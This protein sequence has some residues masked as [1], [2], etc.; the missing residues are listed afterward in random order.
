MQKILLV[1][2]FFIPTVMA[3]SFQL[4]KPVICDSTTLIF[5]ALFEQAGERPM[6]L[7]RGDGVDT[8]QTV[9]LVNKSTKTWTIV[10]FNKDKACVLESGVGSREIFNGPVI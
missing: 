8:S 1:I 3:Q 10:Q 6:W 4:Q 9:L 5:Q 2:F 7:G